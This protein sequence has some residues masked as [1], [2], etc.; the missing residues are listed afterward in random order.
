VRGQERR[1]FLTG[2]REERQGGIT[3]ST[4][5]VE[6]SGGRRCKHVRSGQGTADPLFA[7]REG[8][9]RGRGVWSD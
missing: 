5:T 1:T 6:G 8:E 9:E 2:A 3:A 7:W 4:R